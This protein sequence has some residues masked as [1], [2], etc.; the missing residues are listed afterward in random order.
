MISFSIALILLVFCILIFSKSLKKKNKV[1]RM[2]ITFFGILPGFLLVLLSFIFL[3][4]ETKNKDYLAMLSAGLLLEV[5][6]VQLHQ[7][8]KKCSLKE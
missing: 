6:S 5:G 8:L 1:G 4:I 7:I 2:L 3:V